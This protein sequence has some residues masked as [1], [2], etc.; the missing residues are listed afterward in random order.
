MDTKK[1]NFILVIL[2]S[3]FCLFLYFNSFW[4]I[5]IFDDAH[6]IVSNLY[7]KDFR[8]LPMFLKGFYTSDTEVPIGMFRPL[9]LL[10]F[11]FNYLFSGIQPLG[12]HIINV[13]LHFLN[14]ILFFSLLRQ[15][16][17]NRAKA[18]D[19]KSSQETFFFTP[20]PESPAIYGGDEWLF[21]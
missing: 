2:F 15:L 5:F 10:T 1:Q 21:W 8:Y 6:S 4:G 11:Y 16:F 17:V 18:R 20:T 12:Y 19:D 9:L 7:I 13:L 14:S 3:F